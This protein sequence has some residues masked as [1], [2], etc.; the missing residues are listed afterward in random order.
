MVVDSD[1]E[2]EDE[3]GRPRYRQA[4]EP[5]RDPAVSSGGGSP[6]AA[7]EAYDAITFAS[8]AWAIPLFG[9]IRTIRR[10][11]VALRVIADSQGGLGGVAMAIWARRLGWLYI[12]GWVYLIYHF[13]VL[14]LASL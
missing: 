11:N 3:I 13:G 1:G 10:A 12:V 5:Y 2:D 6:R 7:R 4:P 9:G 8:Y 14:F